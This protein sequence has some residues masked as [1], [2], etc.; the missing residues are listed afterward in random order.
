MKSAGLFQCKTGKVWVNLKF[1][2]VAAAVHRVD[3]VKGKAFAIFWANSEFNF[4]AADNVALFITHSDIQGAMKFLTATIHQYS[5]Q[6]ERN[7]IDAL[8][9]DFWIIGIDCLRARKPRQQ[10]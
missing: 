8:N 4:V 6:I 3:I 10:A 2:G 1:K 9:Y 5:T 7:T